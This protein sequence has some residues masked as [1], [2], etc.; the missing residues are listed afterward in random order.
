MIIKPKYM[1]LVSALGYRAD[2]G[3]S[4]VI[5]RGLDHIEQRVT[6]VL[7]AEMRSTILFPTIGGIDPGAKT[8]TFTVVDRVGRAGIAGPRGVDIAEGAEFLTEN[9]SGIETYDAQYG[10]TTAE[11]RANAMANRGQGP[12]INLESIRA[13]TAAQMIARKIDS[14][15]AFGEPLRLTGSSAIRGVLNNA[16]VTVEAAPLH[17]EDMTP[18]ELLSELFALANR[19]F[20]ISKEA[21]LSD[22]ILLPTDHH[23]LVSTL[24]YGTAGL[25]TVLGFFNDAM[26]EQGRNVAVKSWPL[27]SL[28]DAA[29]TGPRAV[30]YKRD[31]SVVGLII[32]AAFIAQPPQAVGLR[33][34]IPCEGICGGAAVRQPLGMYYRDGL[35]EISA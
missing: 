3:E 32:P 23:Q 18:D 10:W 11:L 21:F 30:S 2:A 17:W 5:Q 14:V 4:L 35:G 15:C 33:W 26:R 7:Y 34:N 1:N 27:L 24:P 28:A 13:E 29:R 31:E 6:E 19:Q 16:N 8:Y 9:T 25:K 20:V 22:T 12:V